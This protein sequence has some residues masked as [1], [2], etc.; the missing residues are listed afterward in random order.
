[1]QQGVGGEGRS[2]AE[3]VLVSWN[4]LES[5]ARR[6]RFRSDASTGARAQGSREHGSREQG[7]EESETPQSEA[8]ST[9]AELGRDARA[10]SVSFGDGPSVESDNVGT[11][12]PELIS[13]VERLRLLRKRG[14]DATAVSKF[15]RKGA[16]RP[17]ADPGRSSNP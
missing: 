7:S 8:Q 11:N 10:Q 6:E 4:D 15:F 2:V 1:V 12:N 13:A 9:T 17:E 14:H 16:S 3:E 5:L